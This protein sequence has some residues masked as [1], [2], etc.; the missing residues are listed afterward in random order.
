MVILTRFAYCTQNIFILTTTCESIT[1][2]Y[3]TIIKHKAGLAKSIPNSLIYYYHIYGLK[4]AQNT[5]KLQHLS[6]FTKALN[7]PNFSSLP[8]KIRL[9][10]LQNAAISNV[11]ILLQQPVFSSNK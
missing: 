3:T 2:K 6:D 11:S 8:L 5:Q 9:Q 10:Q 4:Q 1:N 7:H